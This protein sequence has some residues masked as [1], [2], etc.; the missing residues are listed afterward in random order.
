MHMHNS[1]RRTLKGMR[2]RIGK[3]K[4]LEL[5]EEICKDDIAEVAQTQA[6]AT[7]DAE[8]RSA[9]DY[10]DMA[11]P[12]SELQFP[13][14]G[15]EATDD[16]MADLLVSDGLPDNA[17]STFYFSANAYEFNAAAGGHYFTDI[18]APY[19]YAFG[20]PPIDSVFVDSSLDESDI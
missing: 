2:D 12:G 20:D 11:Y 15:P 13:F 4:L 6:T 17:D 9:G 18:S 8:N 5:T 14:G 1:Y 7:E 16:T 19:A 10:S 3:A